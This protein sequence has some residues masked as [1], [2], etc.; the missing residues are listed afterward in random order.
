[1]SA[2]IIGGDRIHTYRD[3]LSRR[4][5]TP[6]LHW[7]GRK[8]SECHRQIPV[9]TRLVVVLVDQVNHGLARKIRREAEDRAVPVVFSRRSLGQLGEVLAAVA[10]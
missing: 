3:Y 7:N 9:G 1:M 6:V 5:F 4:G 10:P 2:L 8:Q